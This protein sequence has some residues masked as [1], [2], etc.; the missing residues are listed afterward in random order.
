MLP[1][2]LLPLLRYREDRMP[3]ALVLLT[4]GAQGLGY[5]YVHAIGP[6]IACAL[7]LLPAQIAVSTIVH[8]QS[9]L[10]MFR[11]RVFNRLIELLMFLQ[12]GMY[13]TKFALHHNRGHHLHYRDPKRDPSTWVR[14]DGTAMSRLAY[15]GHYFL[16][17]NYHVVRIGRAHPHLLLQCALQVVLSYVALAAIVYARPA[18]AA[19]FFVTPIFVVWLNFIHLTYDDHIEL[20]SNDPYAASHTKTHRVLNVV[21]FNNGY[22]L[23]HHLRPGL[24]WAK[25]PEFH[26]Q[27]ATRI[28]AP[29]SNTPL[30]RLFR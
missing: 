22:H 20:Y 28:K 10:G 11:S 3:L 8:N 24:H 19:I 13:T 29:P 23:A 12:T 6:A 17:Y 21:F 16:T 27:I 18:A 5:L 26:R 15:I 4:S 14:T 2:R 9:H 25:L 1:N 30:N 7:L